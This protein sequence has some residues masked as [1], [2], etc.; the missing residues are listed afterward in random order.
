MRDLGVLALPQSRKH[1]LK[2]V[3]RQEKVR[4]LGKMLLRSR[5]TRVAPR[6]HNSKGE[7]GATGPLEV[8]LR[9]QM[10]N[11]AL[12]EEIRT[13]ISDMT[14]RHVGVLRKLE[15]ALLADLERYE[16][17]DKFVVENAGG[18]AQTECAEQFRQ[19]EEDV[20]AIRE[21]YRIDEHEV[22]LWDTP[23][24][25]EKNARIEAGVFRALGVYALCILFA[26]IAWEMFGVSHPEY[27]RLAAYT[28]TMGGVGWATLGCGGG[29]E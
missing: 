15:A 8:M 9:V 19:L 26:G 23:R 13:E 17:E 28:M 5:V 4:R 22:G 27:L 21:K 18:S 2:G 29:L 6:A 12:K 16:D 10:R 24:A 20:A 7:N 1:R 11:A 3:P 14:E 25:L